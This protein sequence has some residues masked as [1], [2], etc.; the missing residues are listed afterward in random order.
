MEI[1][2][3]KKWVA[4]WG[5]AVS[6][7]SQNHAEFIEDQS[8]RYV[9]FPTVA[10][11]AL[12]LHFSNRYGPEAVRIAGVFVAKRASGEYIIPETNA[13]V[14]FGG[15]PDLIMQAG[16]DAVSDPVPFSFEAGEEFCV[17]IYFADLT[18]LVTGHSNNGYYIKKYY[19]KGNWAAAECVPLEEYGENGPY[20]GPT[21]WHTGYTTSG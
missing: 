13:R 17:S 3:E 1:E 10:G 19:G 20:V 4:G 12:R 15:N 16:E 6:V 14:T 2:T 5:C 18:R 7:V 8:F 21:P 9:I 11:S